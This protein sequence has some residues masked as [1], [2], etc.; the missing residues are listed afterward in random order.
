MPKRTELP[1]QEKTWR[2]IKC[3][4]LNKRSQS[5][6]SVILYGSNYMISWK[7]QTMQIVKRSVVT[8]AWEEGGMDWGSTEDLGA[9]NLSCVILQWRVYIIRYLSNLVDWRTPRANPQ[10]NDGL[11]V[12]VTCRCRCTDRNESF[13]VVHEVDNGGGEACIGQ[14]VRGVPYFLLSFAVN[15]KLSKD[16]AHYK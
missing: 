10:R 4:L 11:W 12:A 14:V 13:T 8:R 3:I 7:K 2:S 15:L 9:G 6:K 1:R 5:E 16:K